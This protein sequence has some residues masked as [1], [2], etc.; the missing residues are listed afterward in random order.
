M[1]ATLIIGGLLIAAT[2]IKNEALV[3]VLLFGV[4][5]GGSYLQRFTSR[6]EVE[7]SITDETIII[8]YL[9]QSF[10]SSNTDQIISFNDIESYKYQPDR[11]FDMFKLTVRNQDE[12]RFWHYTGFADDDF[13]KLVTDF[14]KIVSDY[15]KHEENIL[16]NNALTSAETKPVVIKREKTL[17]EGKAG[18]IL[19]VLAMIFIVTFIYLLITNKIAGASAAFGL[20][21]SISGAVFFLTQF[22]KYRKNQQ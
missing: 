6:G 1:F 13:Q 12:I 11:N 19:A 8:K 3:I 20:L 4:M 10:L 15:N 22:F 2:G 5:I 17:F 7:I 21:A 9:K 14:P 18:L 16:V